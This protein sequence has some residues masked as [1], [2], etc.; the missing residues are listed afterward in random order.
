M[1]YFDKLT[2][3]FASAYTNSSKH[4][5][6]FLS[7]L[8]IFFER[9]NK[10]KSTFARLG[11][12]FRNS[13]WTDLKVQNIKTPL[14]ANWF[15]WAFIMF[16]VSVLIFGFFGKIYLSKTLIQIPFLTDIFDGIFFLW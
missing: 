15:S 3:F 1:R 7:Y 8:R 12:T 2:N 13:K 5:S 10:F 11:N 14:I 16:I 6:S 9:N 4:N